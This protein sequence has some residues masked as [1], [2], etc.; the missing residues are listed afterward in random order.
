MVPPS[1]PPKARREAAAQHVLQQ[2][3]AVIA[4]ADTALATLAKRCTRQA[5]ARR[6]P[7]P[8]WR[9]PTS[10][11]SA[12]TPGRARSSGAGARS[13]GR[14]R[15]SS[16][17]RKPLASMRSTHSACSR[18]H[19]DTAVL[20]AG[21]AQPRRPRRD[22]LHA[23][24]PSHRGDGCRDRAAVLGARLRRARPA[25]YSPM[26]F[27]EQIPALRRLRTRTAMRPSRCRP[28][29]SGRAASLRSC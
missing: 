2:Q 3:S 18:R 6:P 10:C 29:A 26:A 21:A 13:L 25:R 5:A 8:S 16:V 11:R 14:A 12:S 9:E 23:Q 7:A 27:E 19:A 24:R 17:M 20:C 4:D 28:Q 22:E 1:E 15:W